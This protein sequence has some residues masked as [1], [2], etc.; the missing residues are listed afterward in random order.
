[1]FLILD[2]KGGVGMEE[3]SNLSKVAMYVTKGYLIVPIQVELYDENIIQ[4]QEDILKKVNE[5]M[6]EGVIIDLSAV[7]I[8]DSKIRC[9]VGT[10][11]RIFN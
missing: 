1:L 4:M 10:P 6:I 5:K 2:F 7:D 8:I 9:P 3:N 11:R